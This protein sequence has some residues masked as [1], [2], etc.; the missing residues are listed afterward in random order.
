M[1]GVVIATHGEFG[2]TLLGTL[3]MILGEMEMVQSVTLAPEDSVEAFRDKMA[4]AVGAVDPQG[5]GALVLVD[6]LGGTPFNVAM[7]MTAQ[8]KLQVVTG[9]NLPMLVKVASHREETDLAALAAEVQKATR[10]SIITSVEL[11]KGKA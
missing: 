11:F 8:Q 6:M 5:H 1:I 3:G 7:G 10:E 4:A 2:K 9:V